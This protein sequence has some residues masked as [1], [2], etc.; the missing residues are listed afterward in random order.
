MVLQKER[1]QEEHQ[2]VHIDQLVEEEKSFFTVIA[3]V[4]E[5]FFDALV[6]I[7]KFIASIFL[8]IIAAILRGGEWFGKEFG[9]WFKNLGASIIKPFIS[10]GKAMKLGQVEISAAK[11]NKGIFGAIAAWFR[12]SGRVIFGKRGIAVTIVNWVLPIASCV[13]LF[14]IVAFANNQSYALKLTVNGNFI[15]YINDE[16]TYNSASQIVQKRINYTGSHTEVVTFDPDYEVDLGGYTSILNTYQLADKLLDLLGDDIADGY[17]V[18]IGDAYYGTV[19][20][21]DAVQNALDGLL[22]KYSTGDANEKVA[23]DKT[24]EFTPGK[25]LADSF[26][27]E[28]TLI[29]MFTSN[30][31]VAAYYTVVENDSPTLICGKVDMTFTELERMNPGF[32]EDTEIHP[33]DRIQI[34]QDEPFLTVMVTREE[35]YTE[36]IPYETTYTSNNM[37]YEGNKAVQTEGVNGERSVI[38]NVSYINGTEISRSVISRSTI[39]QPINE[40]IAVGTLPRPTSAASGITIEAGKMLW[41]VGG[42][43]GGEI[44]EMP[45]GHGGYYG[46]KGIDVMAAYGTPIYAA[47]NGV[48]T[49]A[50]YGYNG[51]CGNYV[52]IQ[53]DSGYETR[54]YHCSELLTS[55]GTRVT[56]GDLIGYVGASG[57]A[58]GAHLHFEVRLGGEPLYPINYLPWHKRQAGCVEY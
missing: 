9:D 41:P 7:L 54:Y 19:L 53:G 30:K 27:N 13:F 48:V 12:V 55:Y 6:S 15:G 21:K 28:Q 3:G 37:I 46:H 23:F 47:E 52:V 57:Y 25:Y 4:G 17:G 49:T 5:F 10:Y 42:Y 38:A 34:T 36:A 8:W 29:D 31:K 51:G 45:Y 11:K 40:V 2:I 22:E 35:H 16:T 43:D 58:E 32:N 26:V 33:G 20:H 24:I 1:L 44:S 39:T 14:N 18:Y 56:A 50:E